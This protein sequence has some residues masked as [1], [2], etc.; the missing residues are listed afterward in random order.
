MRRRPSRIRNAL[1]GLSTV[2]ITAGLLLLFDAGL[3]LVWQEPVSAVYAHVEQGRL[4][5]QLATSE[6]SRLSDLER[7]ALAQ[8][9]S[10]RR[11]VAFLARQLRRDAKT[12]QAIGRIRIPRIGAD[13][14]V[15]QGTDTSSLQKGP[16]HYPETP[17]PGARGT[18]AI[19]GHRTT[20][21]APFRHIDSLRHGDAVILEMPYARVTYRVQYTRIVDP[22]DIGVIRREP[23]D[24]LVMTACHPLYSAAKRIVVFSRLSAIE[25]RGAAVR[26]A[27]D[28]IKRA[29]LRAAAGGLATPPK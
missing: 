1:R 26:A 7:R 6:A 25:P 12:G 18:T 21:L 10:D 15:V 19:A 22:T 29:G 23:Y 3:T 27:W 16:G 20:Y 8:F 17:L 11:R 5:S 14:V 28:R 2:L 4:D 24:R 13:F 9:G